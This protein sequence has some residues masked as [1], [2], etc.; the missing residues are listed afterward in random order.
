MVEFA[1]QYEVDNFKELKF[2]LL[3]PLDALEFAKAQNESFQQL[4]NFFDL[5]YFSGPRP[6]IET[7]NILMATIRSQV[8]DLFGLYRAGRLLGIGQYH[9]T[10]YSQNGCQIVIWVR[11]SEMGKK[12]GA[13]LLKRLTLHAI[14]EKNF[15]FVEL[16]IDD[17]NEASRA[18]ATKVGYEFI[19]SFA[20]QTQGRQ[21]SG[22]YCRYLCFD[23]N[24]DDLAHQYGLR[25]I[26][27]IEHPAYEKS[28]RGLI[29]DP[30]VNEAFAWETLFDE[31]FN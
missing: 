25:K 20:A 7:F 4:S 8:V 9:F 17:N 31:E 10:S 12:I 26:D 22:V 29:H 11:Q 28:L 21:G 1:T 24:I 19:E 23:T 2:R 5:D 30:R 18:T 15:R 6:F 16:L 14:Y 13:Y 27:L 3:N